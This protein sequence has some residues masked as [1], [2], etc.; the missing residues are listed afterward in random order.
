MI[1]FG[2]EGVSKR[3][4]TIYYGQESDRKSHR[5]FIMAKN[6]LERDPKIR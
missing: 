4:K 6:G 2:Q 3:Q 1:Y 5:R